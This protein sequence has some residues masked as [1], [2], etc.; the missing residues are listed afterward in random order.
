MIWDGPSSV[1]AA[2]DQLLGRYLIPGTVT[3]L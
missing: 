1:D 3:A 2:V